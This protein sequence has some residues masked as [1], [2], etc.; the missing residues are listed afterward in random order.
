MRKIYKRNFKR[1]DN[2]ELLLFGYEKHNELAG[3]QIEINEIS[4]PH[5]RWNPSR[6]EWVTYSS[7]RRD[8]TS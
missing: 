8:R 6:N 4:N 3:A 2:K 5:M 1:I 7:G